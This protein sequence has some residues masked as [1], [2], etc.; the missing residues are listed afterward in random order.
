MGAHDLAFLENYRKITER[1]WPK[2]VIMRPIPAPRPVPQPAP[3]P[4]YQPPQRLEVFDIDE[5]DV[6]RWRKI[7][8]EVA[9]KWELQPDDVLGRSRSPRPVAAR[10]ELCRRMRHELGWSLSRIGEKIGRD[11][12]TVLHNLGGR[13]AAVASVGWADRPD[14]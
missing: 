6:P 14:Q 5:G 12:T 8:R 11:H 1:F 9:I 2:P 10:K 7:L 3:P 4:V 13:A